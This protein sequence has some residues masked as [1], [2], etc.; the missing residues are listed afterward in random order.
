MK[1]Q[2]N[3]FNYNINKNEIEVFNIFDH[4]RFCK[5]V[6]DSLKKCETKEEFSTQLKRNLT[7]YYWA[8]CEWEVIVTSWPPRI[9]AEEFERL[10]DE[11]EKFHKEH[12][13]YPPYSMYVNLCVGKKVDI[14]SQVM[15]NF[16]IF[17]DYVWSHK[18]SKQ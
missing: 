17:V 10:T 11:S 15:L 8:K 2:W 18:R 14:Y 16:D 1:L 5:D 9:N 7:Y 12:G 6:K 13:I 4:G 3:V